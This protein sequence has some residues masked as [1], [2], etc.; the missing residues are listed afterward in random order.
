MLPLNLYWFLMHVILTVCPKNWVRFHNSCYKFSSKSASWNAAK[1]SCEAQGSHL[2]VINSRAENQAIGTRSSHT[3]FI[4]LHRDPKDQ[5]RW[6]WV[7]GSRPTFTNWYPGEPNNHGG[8]E[9]CVELYPQ[10]HGLK[11]NDFPCSGPRR[12][13]CETS[14]ESIRSWPKNTFRLDA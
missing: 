10:K 6:L 12:Y 13:I 1:A 9:A 7:D 14:G 2:V 8:G 4:G 11:W 3:M 5:S